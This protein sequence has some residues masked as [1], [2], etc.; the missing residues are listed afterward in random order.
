MK[1]ACNEKII[2][3]IN[4]AIKEELKSQ[5]NDAELF[6]DPDLVDE[7]LVECSELCDKLLTHDY[8]KES[9]SILDEWSNLDFCEV[10]YS[11]YELTRLRWESTYNKNLK[12]KKEDLKRLFKL[13]AN[14][15]EGWC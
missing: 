14:Y 9:E 12:E 8:F 1:M 6:N 7:S 4:E 2:W 13:I 15:S 10:R 3:S 5:V 11:K